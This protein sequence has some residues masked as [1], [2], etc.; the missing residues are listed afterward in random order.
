MTALG[1]G[2][3]EDLAAMAAGMEYGRA[4]DEVV[5]AALERVGANV[6]RNHG[7]AVHRFTEPGMDAHAPARLRP[8][9]DAWHDALDRHGLTI[10]DTERFTVC[11]TLRVAGTF[12]HLVRHPDHGLVV[13]DKKTGSLH[14][15]A[16]AV[17]L[18]VYARGMGYVIGDAGNAARWELGASFSVGIVAHIPYGQPD[19]CDLHLVDL[20][21]GWQAA[22]AAAWV[23]DW[24]SRKD[25][26]T[27]LT[28]PGVADNRRDTA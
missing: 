11:D 26:L 14:P 2:R 13:L 5:E 4:V 12:D 21:A 20:D 9:V 6:K 18:A 1:V 15:H 3:H 16:V 28:P 7:T 19:V 10:V 23:R 8:V 27:P 22:K 17:Q 25:I 24:R